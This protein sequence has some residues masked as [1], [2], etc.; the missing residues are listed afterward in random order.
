MPDSPFSPRRIGHALVRAARAMGTHETP[1]D[2]GSISYFALIALFPFILML[3]AFADTILGWWE[4]HDVVLQRIAAL[5]P[6]S[7]DFLARNLNEI[8]DPSPALVLSC[9][10]AVLWLS[11]WIFSSMENA[12]N[13]AW[14]VPRRRSFWQS[15]LRS[16][17]L[18][19]LGGALLMTSAGITA[20]VSA[21]R[22][23]ATDMVPGYA[24]DQ[25]INWLWSSILLG[26]GF[27][28]AICVFF[29]I[30][31]LMPDRRVLWQEAISGA[32]FA[33]ALWETAAYMF[34]RLLPIFDPQKV[35][36]R[37]GVFI[38]LLAW[39]YTSTLILL[40]GANFSAQLHQNG[41]ET[42]RSADAPSAAQAKLREPA[43]I[44]AFPINR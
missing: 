10:F 7:R 37:T 31:K 29:C 43:R 28:L 18:L 3:V 12:L 44:R 19:I 9:G 39:V 2:A 8:I 32:V 26:S 16:I 4:L 14:R 33:A 5:F 34:V 30:Y 42:A 11:T 20:F 25:I 36:G 27:I 40:F 15:R 21:V 41:E 22:L 1:R 6:G 17:T 13:R 24:Q 23:R 35:Y 38:A